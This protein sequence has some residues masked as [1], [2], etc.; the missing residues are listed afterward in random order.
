MPLRHPFSMLELGILRHPAPCHPG[1]GK[2]PESAFS[3]SDCNT[4]SRPNFTPMVRQA[5]FMHTRSLA[6]PHCFPDERVARRASRKS[7]LR[8][9]ARYGH[10]G[11]S[12][13][14]DGMEEIDDFV[15]QRLPVGLF[16]RK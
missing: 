2:T 8:H 3:K 5:V 1:G 16:G 4:S 11:R 10:V 6:V 12:R 14:A 13:L 9:R 15:H 7:Q